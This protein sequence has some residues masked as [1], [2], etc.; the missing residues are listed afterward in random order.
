MV[1]GFST[2]FFKEVYNVENI[3]ISRE[4]LVALH[5]S[6]GIGCLTIREL[7]EQRRP[8]REGMRE[9]DLRDMGLSPKQALNAAKRLSPDRMK[10]SRERRRKAGVEVL[11]LA[12]P[13][14]PVKLL[15]TNYAPAVLYC[16]GNLKMANRPSIAVVGTRMATAYGRHIAE[17]YAE[18]FAERGLTVV[19]G[20]AKGIDTCAHRGALTRAGGTVAVLGLPVDVIYPPENRQLYRQIAERGLL[21]SEAP[22]DTPYH[23]GMFPAR[24]R[25]IAGMSLGV[26]VVEAPR[27]S[28]ALITADKAIEAERPVFVIP[29]PVTSPRSRGGL[30]LL[31]EGTAQPLI[32]PDGV[33]AEFKDYV[34]GP[35]TSGQSGMLAEVT[36]S[37]EESRVHELLL[38]GPRTV[39]EIS[40]ETGISFGLLNAALLS[41]QIKKKIRQQPGAVYAPL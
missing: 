28:G 25:I 19:S 10:A 3:G 11:T 16:I 23:K 22:P 34:P 39:E 26:V 38:D 2:S 24:N 12:D 29:A 31:K 6:D 36:L 4:T 32:D 1:P 17:S 41:L 5:E 21:L 40:A 37:E 15:D 8:I 7:W 13:E 33:W 18:D 27:D 9:G 20:L 14:Y 30:E 35:E